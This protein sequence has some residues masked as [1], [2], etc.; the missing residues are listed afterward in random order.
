MLALGTFL[1]ITLLAA[2][3]DSTSTSA[4]ARNAVE[5]S[6]PFI[7]KEGLRW[8]TERKCASC[9]HVPMMV[10]TLNE[11]KRGGFKINE[12]VAEENGRWLVSSPECRLILGAEHKNQYFDGLEPGPVFA[13]LAMS[14]GANWNNDTKAAWNKIAD[15]ARSRQLAD[16]SFKEGIGRP[17]IFD[18]PEVM[19]LYALLLWTSPRLDAKQQG[20]VAA[21]R[22]KSL[23]WLAKTPTDGRQRS[24]AMRLFVQSRVEA[25]MEERQ[26][27]AE[28][29]IALQRPD[30]SW[31]QIEKMEGDVFATGESLYALMV[32]GVQIPPQVISN[33]VEFLVK[34]QK[35]DGSWGMKTRPVLA[36]P[37]DP[38]KEGTQM[39]TYMG[40]AWGTLG[41]IRAA[42]LPVSSNASQGQK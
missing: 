35:A 40:S 36:K 4:S 14:S 24:L 34:T 33:A 27:I 8:K 2:A 22:E 25:P 30:G 28:R 31:R 18:Q 15:Y 20:E 10:W 19:T 23:Q 12:Q 5:K 38:L 13:S 11:A 39:I 26:K 17:P 41:L 6:L 21:L 9:H 3:P 7:E 32:S 1:A 37:D 29:L 42:S 16:G